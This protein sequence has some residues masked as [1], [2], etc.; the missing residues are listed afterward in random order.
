MTKSILAL[1]DVLS[2]F[3]RKE[4][5]QDDLR[6]LG[7]SSTGKKDHLVYRLLNV[8]R[9]RNQS[10][11]DT[12]ENI[13]SALPATELKALAGYIG[14]AAN[15]NRGELI[16]NILDSVNFEPYVESI[17]RW[18]PICAEKTLQEIH[19]DNNWRQVYFECTVCGN[20]T[21]IEKTSAKHLTKNVEN[22]KS[23]STDTIDARTASGTL[24][25]TCIAIFLTLFFGLKVSVSWPVSLL[26]ASF[27]FV[28][29]L[30]ILAFTKP[31][32][33]KYIVI[34]IQKFSRS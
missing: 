34:L 24:I 17:E 1:D 23:E 18:C 29:S 20:K 26:I 11:Q 2:Q 12:G 7:I 19:Y 31:Y 30:L 27:A 22:E 21:T 8:L 9:T 25:S 10:V 13:I 32:W 14:I 5:I 28:A 3:Y 33:E 16:S 4:W 6:K 15:G